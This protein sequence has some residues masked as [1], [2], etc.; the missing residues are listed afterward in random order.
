MADSPIIFQPKQNLIFHFKTIVISHIKRHKNSLSWGLTHGLNIRNKWKFDFES[1]KSYKT[2]K[3]WK[4]KNEMDRF[5]DQNY[6][7]GIVHFM[8]ILS[9]LVRKIIGHRRNKNLESKDHFPLD[10]TTQ[11]TVQLTLCSLTS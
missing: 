9:V 4:G 6:N 11:S 2:K 3:K 8:G 5:F 7:R 1:Y 10:G